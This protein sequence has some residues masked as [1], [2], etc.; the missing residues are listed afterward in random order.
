MFTDLRCVVEESYLKERHT[1]VSHDGLLPRAIVDA[2]DLPVRELSPVQ[3]ECVANKEV[4][5]S[6]WVLQIVKIHVKLK[7][8]NTRIQESVDVIRCCVLSPRN[9][10]KNL[11]HIYF[12][13]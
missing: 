2:H 12:I 1:F 4:H 10:L 7:A 6:V 3:K 8:N 5:H 11:T 13:I 9:T